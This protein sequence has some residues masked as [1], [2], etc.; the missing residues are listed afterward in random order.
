MSMEM[1]FLFSHLDFLA[2]NCG[3]VSDEH[4]E[5]FH[6]YISVMQHRYKW[7]W[8][9]AILGDNYRMMLL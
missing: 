5:P 7:K 3:A 1:P 4:G 9:A 2:L 6:Q 8:S